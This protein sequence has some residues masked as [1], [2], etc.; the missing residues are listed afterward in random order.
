MRVKELESQ[1]G[2]AKRKTE[3]V[4]KKL[5]KATSQ[6]RLEKSRTTSLLKSEH[7]D[8]KVNIVQLGI[9]QY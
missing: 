3:T 4:A 6:L 8:K 5:G 9:S 2:I 7:L 1:L